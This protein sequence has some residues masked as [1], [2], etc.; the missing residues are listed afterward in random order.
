MRNVVRGRSSHLAARRPKP[1]PRRTSK[2]GKATRRTDRRVAKRSYTRTLFTRRKPRNP[3][4]NTGYIGVSNCIRSHSNPFIRRMKPL[5][6]PCDVM[7]TGALRI[8]SNQ[9]EQ[10]IGTFTYFNGPSTSNNGAGTGTSVQELTNAMNNNT[11]PQPSSRTIIDGYSVDMVMTNCTTQTVNVK[12]LDIMP[13]RDIPVGTVAKQDPYQAWFR[14]LAMTNITGSQANT[15]YGNEGTVTLGSTPYRSI[16]FTEHYKVIK[17]TQFQLSPGGNHRHCIKHTLNTILPKC[18]W[19]ESTSNLVD[20][21]Y[22]TYQ[23]QHMTH[24]CII[25]VWGMPVNSTLTKTNVA[26]PVSALDV[27]WSYKATARYVQDATR[28]TCLITNTINQLATVADPETIAEG[29]SNVI[30]MAVS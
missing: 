7:S 17:Q 3:G 6:S 9:N 5:A 16:M 21:N 15:F 4:T 12:I 1:T 2:I 8:Q 23:I 13:R 25:I 11:T 26:I 20:T 30:N 27:A 10:G 19:F 18:R 24:N 22:D 28:S 29:N 14:G